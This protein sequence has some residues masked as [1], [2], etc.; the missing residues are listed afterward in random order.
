MKKVIII[1]ALLSSLYADGLYL[2]LGDGF[3]SY[4]DYET[5]TTTTIVPLGDGDYII[6]DK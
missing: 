6:S 2:D 3:G 4:T 1:T 5:G